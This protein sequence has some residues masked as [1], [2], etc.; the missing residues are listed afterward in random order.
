M[1]AKKTKGNNEGIR[2]KRTTRIKRKKGYLG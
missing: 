1:E 2:K